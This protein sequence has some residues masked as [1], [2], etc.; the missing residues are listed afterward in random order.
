MSTMGYDINITAPNIWRKVTDRRQTCQLMY[1]ASPEVTFLTSASQTV[2]LFRQWKGYLSRWSISI[3][4]TTVHSTDWLN[5]IKICPGKESPQRM[6]SCQKVSSSTYS[7]FRAL[8]GTKNRNMCSSKRNV[9]PRWFRGTN[10]QS[11]P[12]TKK[13]RFMNLWRLF[14]IQ[15]ENKAALVNICVPNF[16]KL[17]ICISVFTNT[18]GFESLVQLQS[19]DSGIVSTEQTISYLTSSGALISTEWWVS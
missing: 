3:A 16:V 13:M 6:A 19:S 14:P 15:G 5:V 8:I 11:K 7:I 10:N 1:P 17:E 9:K 2:W 18:K 12:S 4:Q